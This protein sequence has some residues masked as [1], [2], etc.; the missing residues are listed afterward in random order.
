M[1]HEASSI[2]QVAIAIITDAQQRVLLTRRALEASHGGFWEFPGG[3]LKES[4]LAEAALVREVE[5]EVG[6]DKLSY[7]YLGQVAHVYDTRSVLLHVYH[8]FQFSGNAEC[9]E[10]QMDLRWVDLKDI[11][12]YKFPAANEKI[13]ELLGQ[14]RSF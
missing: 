4:E 9:R 5:E 8:V 2:I 14:L 10:M 13:V 12:E 1:K 7:N 11:Q 3:K 6:L